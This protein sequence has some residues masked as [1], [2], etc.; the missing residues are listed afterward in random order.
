MGEYFEAILDDSD[1]D[2][3][4]FEDSVRAA[5]RFH[6]VPPPSELRG[7]VAAARARSAAAAAGDVERLFVLCSAMNCWEGGH[8]LDDG[9]SLWMMRLHEFC[10]QAW[11]HNVFSVPAS[12][13]PPLPRLLLAHKQAGVDWYLSCCKAVRFRKEFQLIKGPLPRTHPAWLNARIFKELLESYLQD[14]RRRLQRDAVP[15]FHEAYERGALVL[16]LW[17]RLH[18]MVERWSK[19]RLEALKRDQARQDAQ[20]RRDD[21]EFNYYKTVYDHVFRRAASAPASG[22]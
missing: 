11:A 9:A 4:A 7:E 21:K 13:T 14:L 3:D 12:A 2:D 22:A 5:V 16:K 17:H 15:A 19:L 20:R 10:R 6:T 1:I 18:A 8:K